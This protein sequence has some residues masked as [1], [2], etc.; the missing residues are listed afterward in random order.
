MVR[1]CIIMKKT[2]ME[3]Y[4]ELLQK[5]VSSKKEKLKAIRTR[6]NRSLVSEPSVIFPSHAPEPKPKLM[7]VKY[8]DK[9][10]DIMH[11]SDQALQ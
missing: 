6:P 2:Y 1:F 9:V 11:K 5:R 7:Q 3:A 8:I 4:E 10:V